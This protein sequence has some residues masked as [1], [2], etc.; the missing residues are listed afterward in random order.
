MTDL[1]QDHAGAPVRRRGPDLLTLV[2][3]LGALAVAGNTLLGGAA[4]LPGLDVRWVL[5]AVAVLIGLLMVISSLR[6]RRH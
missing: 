3:G 2:V 6:P 1:S 4:W 5:A